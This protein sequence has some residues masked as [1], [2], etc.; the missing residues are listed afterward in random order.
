MRPDTLN[1]LPAHTAE[2][3]P[4]IRELFEEYAR[5]LEHSVCLR[6]FARELAGLPG[7]YAPPEGQL[8]LARREG[9]AAGCAGLRK[10]AEGVCEMKR[11]YVRAPFRR[12]GC[13]RALAEALIQAARAEGYQRMRLD[14]LPS[15]REA[16]ALYASLGFQ[17]VPAP[18][19]QD[20]TGPMDLELILR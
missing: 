15:M 8:L 12:R 18:D 3:L 1:I 6:D 4:A 13:G 11:L 10:L 16:V 9:Q 17:R 5:T 20:G 19:K 2:H 14:T 7:G